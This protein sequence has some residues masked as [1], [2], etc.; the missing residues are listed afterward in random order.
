MSTEKLTFY[1]SIVC[2]YAQRVAITLKEVGADFERVEIDL[3]NKPEWY[4]DVNPDLKVPALKVG[5]STLAESLV[6]VELLNDLYPEKGLLPKD[7]LKRAQIRFAIEHYSSKVA[8]LW[9]KHI[10][11]L[12]T[13]EGRQTY[14]EELDAGLRRLN[15]LLLQQASSGPYFLGNEYSIADIA[16]GPF[17]QRIQLFNRLYLNNFELEILKELPRLAEFFQAITERPSAKETLVSDEGFIKS[18]ARF[19]IPSPDQY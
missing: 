17:V 7:P 14:V 19:G 4:K 5:D 15:E 11:Q 2:P 13:S 16:I 8:P 6:L 9:Y 10:K 3:S 12:N 1:T 18:L